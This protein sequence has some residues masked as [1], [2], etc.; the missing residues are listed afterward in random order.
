MLLF[1][2]IILII[3]NECGWNGC[4]D[5]NTINVKRCTHKDIYDLNFQMQTLECAENSPLL[6]QGIPFRI[7]V[8]LIHLV[9]H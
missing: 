7:N 4:I 2:Y 5:M 3:I 1:V 9:P 6:L 8:V